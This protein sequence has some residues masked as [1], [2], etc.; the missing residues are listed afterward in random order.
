MGEDVVPQRFAQ[1]ARGH[2]RAMYRLGIFRKRRPQPFVEG[3]EV[4]PDCNAGAGRSRHDGR[5]R[6]EAGRFADLDNIS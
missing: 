3:L 4:F 2:A 6:G 5:T 1:A